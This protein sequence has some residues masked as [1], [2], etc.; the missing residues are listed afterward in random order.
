MNWN[1]CRLLCSF[2]LVLLLAACSSHVQPPAELGEMSRNDFMT[3]MRWKNFKAA[4]SHL[5]PEHRQAF[6]KTFTS[7]KDIDITD[8]RL[9]D[10][11][12][13]DEGQR[14]ETTVVMEYYL[15]PSVT[16]KT[17]SFDQT[18][19]FFAG[20]DPAHQGFFIATPFPD[21]P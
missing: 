7:L 2:M 5:Q 10:L 11:Q 14:F 21:F 3:A 18:W 20:A 19:L 6:M 16:V 15:L 12:I 17:F 8:V 9:A 4:A 13:Y 1:F